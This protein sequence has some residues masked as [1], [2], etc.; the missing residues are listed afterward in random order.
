MTPRKIKEAVESTASLKTVQRLIKKCA[1]LSR[2]RLKKK[3]VLTQRAL[4]KSPPFY[5]KPYG[6]TRSME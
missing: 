5:K 4:R 3:N 6:V 1:H 2:R